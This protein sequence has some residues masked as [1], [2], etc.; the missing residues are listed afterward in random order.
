VGGEHGGAFAY[1]NGV[2]HC[3]GRNPALCN[4]EYHNLDEKCRLHVSIREQSKRVIYLCHNIQEYLV[5]GAI[6]FFSV[7]H[8]YDC[9][10]DTEWDTIG[11][12]F[13]IIYIER[14]AD[15][16]KRSV[17]LFYKKYIPNTIKLAINYTIIH[18]VCN[19]N[20]VGYSVINTNTIKLG[21]NYTISKFFVV[22]NADA[23]ELCV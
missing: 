20:K 19:R 11:K 6:V 4:T 23:Y 16:I 17:I 10:G 2:L 18:I 1:R 12:L 7:L 9:F 15:N 13:A 8:L 3:T 21:I 5:S 14:V 22:Y